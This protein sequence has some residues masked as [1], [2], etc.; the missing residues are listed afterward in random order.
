MQ[1]RSPPAEQAAAG[2][3]VSREDTLIFAADLTDIIT[4]DP[5]VV[6]E[7]SGTELAGNIYETLVSFNPGEPGKLVPVLAQ[8]W[9]V[10]DDGDMWKLTFN[11]NPNA[12]FASG[13]PVTAADVV[14]SWGR[15]IDINKS[16]AFLLTDVCQITK[17]NVT[18]VD[19]A[20]LEVKL[21]KTVSPQ[22][23]LSVLTFTTASVVETGR[24]RA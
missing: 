12:K 18:A 6:Y 20:T 21:P 11:I 10:A 22:V 3:E 17:E 2:G 16:P 1:R 19:A 14:F 23:C 9:D 7:F 8:S 4:L 5:A 15:A 13:N 24:C